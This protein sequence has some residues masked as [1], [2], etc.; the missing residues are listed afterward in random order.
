MVGRRR[1]TDERMFDEEG[2]EVGARAHF[3][4]DEKKKKEL[5][6]PTVQAETIILP[7]ANSGYRLVSGLACKV[8]VV[9]HCIWGVKV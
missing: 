2:Q 1:R 9:F 3:L 7:G 4:V 6:C 5:L 8:S